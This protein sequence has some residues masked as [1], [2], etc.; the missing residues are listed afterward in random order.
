[1]AVVGGEEGGVA[2]VA[3]GEA[4]GEVG[5]EAGG[6]TQQLAD[7]ALL[8]RLMWG[9]AIYSRWLSEVSGCF[10]HQQGSPCRSHL[11]C[12]IMAQRGREWIETQNTP[13]LKDAGL[14][15]FRAAVVLR[16]AVESGLRRHIARAEASVMLQGGWTAESG[17]L[18]QQLIDLHRML[19]DLD[20]RDDHLCRE[21]RGVQ[22]TQERLRD[23]LLQPLRRCWEQHS[24]SWFCGVR[25]DPKDVGL[26]LSDKHRRRHD[27][28]ESKEG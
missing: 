26:Y 8:L 3:G 25:I 5:G 4:G 15:A 14:A 16:P 17:R 10:S 13:S 28:I 23:S 1:M 20:V 2:G 24:R 18:M 12:R 7:E 21:Q 19:K 6:K 9:H 22:F 11:V 27:L